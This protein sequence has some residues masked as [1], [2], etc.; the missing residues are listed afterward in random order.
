MKI[1]TATSLACLIAALLLILAP[2]H[3]VPFADAASPAPQAGM[4]TCSSDNGRRNFCAADV[5]GRSWRT[6]TAASAG[7]GALRSTV[8]AV[9]PWRPLAAPP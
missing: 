8:G 9:R 6:A 7:A 3:S 1:L 2:G 5:R 4:V